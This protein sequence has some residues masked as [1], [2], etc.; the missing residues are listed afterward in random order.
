MLFKRTTK[1]IRTKIEVQR[2]EKILETLN[3]GHTNVILPSKTD[4]KKS[5]AMGQTNYYI[6][7]NYSIHKI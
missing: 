5:A 7:V 4:F 3:K 2:W 1:N 6:I